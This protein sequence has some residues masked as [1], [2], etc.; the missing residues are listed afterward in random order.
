MKKRLLVGSMCTV[1]LTL[2]LAGVRG[3]TAEAA[4][5]PIYHDIRKDSGEIFQGDNFCQRAI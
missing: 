1:L 5:I 3:Q 4:D 2:L